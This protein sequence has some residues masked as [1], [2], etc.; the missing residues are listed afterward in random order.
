MTLTRRSTAALVL[1]A[2]AGSAVAAT[3]VLAAKKGRT[4]TTTTTTTTTTTSSLTPV[5]TTTP[6]RLAA[7]SVAL[8]DSFGRV[9]RPDA[10]YAAGGVL[11]TSA[12]AISRTSSPALYQFA[13]SGVTSYTVPVASAGTYFVDMFV[14]ET[15][16]ALPGQRVFSVAAEGA[17]AVTNIDIVSEAGP[18][19]AWH[20]MFAAPVTDGTLN[21]ALSASAAK[22][23]VG[24]VAISY[25]SAATSPATT[26]ND[27]FDGSAGTAP[28]ASKWG[29]AYGGNGWGN[30]ELQYYTR[31]TANASTDGSGNLSITARQGAYTGTDGVT[32]QYTSARLTT[33]NTFQF[34]YG[35]VESRLRVPTGKGLLPAF[36]ALGTDLP[37]VGWPLCGEIDIMENLGSEPNTVHST[38][39]S[40]ISGLT[41]EW[42]SGA[43][44]TSPTPYSDGFHTFR[45][46]WG[47]NGISVSDDGKTF[48]TVSA[49]D[50]AP[51]NLWNFNHPFYLLLNMAVGG[52]WPGSPDA[53][54]VFPA[55][56]SVDYVRVT[57]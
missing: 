26:F 20:V 21:L 15:K 52:N 31:D 19:K 33:T 32:R 11:T 27:D 50:I 28:N 13:R 36:W 40:G 41:G 17:P 9:F 30:N 44:A 45:L 6:V 22:P 18:N 5:T 7:A 14:A 48:F 57:G 23:L 53:T 29:L 4:G 51:G 8:T 16:G 34:Q 49:S 37:S 38:I 24:A 42:L 47:P 39:H 55:T 56:M 54:T 43:L 25:Q 10:G 46:V 35:T 12:N 1:A 2:L 3:P